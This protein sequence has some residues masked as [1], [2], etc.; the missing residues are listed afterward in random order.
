VIS[1][2]ASTVFIYNVTRSIYLHIC[3][4]RVHTVLYLSKNEQIF[5]CRKICEDYSI[6][7]ELTGLYSLYI[8]GKYSTRSVITWDM[9]KQ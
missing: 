8:D 2:T 7:V 5:H 1:F 9:L 3:L 4:C 6:V